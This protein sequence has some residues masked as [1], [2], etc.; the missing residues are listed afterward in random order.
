MST[1]S[2]V[3]KINRKQ[4]FYLAFLSLLLFWKLSLFIWL[5]YPNGD[6]PWSLGHTFSIIQGEF[7]KNNKTK[8]MYSLGKKSNK[9]FTDKYLRESIVV[10]AH[11]RN[12]GLE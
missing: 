3:A 5:P 12:M 10:T 9:N 4:F 6:G 2:L 8:T 1:Q 7:F 11:T